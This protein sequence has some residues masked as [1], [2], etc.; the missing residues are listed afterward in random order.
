[1]HQVRDK[2]K[3]STIKLIFILGQAQALILPE[4]L[5][6]HTEGKSYI[7]SPYE[8]NKFANTQYINIKPKSTTEY[9][10]LIF[11][12]FRL[13]AK[14]RKAAELLI[15]TPHLMNFL[16]NKFYF[17][18]KDKTKLYYLFDGTLNYRPVSANEEPALSYQNRQKIKSLAVFHRYV[19]LRNQIVDTKLQGAQAFIGPN[20]MIES[21]LLC[22]LPIHKLNIELGEYNP[23]R[24][25]L[26]LEPILPSDK[27]IEFENWA[28]KVI[29][30]NFPGYQLI[31][32][33]HPSA[34]ASLLNKSKMSDCCTD[35]VVLSDKSPAELIFSR[36]GCSVVLSTL[37]SA[38][39]LIKTAFPLTQ[40]YITTQTQIETNDNLHIIKLVMKEL[41]VNIS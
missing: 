5:K 37:S 2:Y 41:G 40:A 7:L 24:K 39:L 31:I 26:L 10:K 19:F 38:T 18:N 34:P 33:P 28:K 30:D 6:T 14:I 35:V 27:L 25:I 12:I 4:L 9:I 13:T 22:D 29:S 20:G 32:K 8:I 15:Y 16:A 36:E 17:A 23:K 11:Q 21:R 1:M 3:E